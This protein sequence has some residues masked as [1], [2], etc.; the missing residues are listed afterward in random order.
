MT[1]LKRLPLPFVGESS[2]SKIHSLLRFSTT[3]VVL[4][5]YPDRR[6]YSVPFPSN[7]A[8]ELRIILRNLKGGSSAKVIF[9]VS[10]R[11]AWRWTLA[12]ASFGGL[13][14]DRAEHRLC[15]DAESQSGGVGLGGTNVRR[16]RLFT[17]WPDDSFYGRVSGGGRCRRR[18]FVDT[19]T[20]RRSIL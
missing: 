11:L 4:E 18:A 10:Q 8:T 6:I 20:G 3:K 5:S 13:F 15:P 17:D 16:R 2:N 14:T 1:A 7:L 9:H 19:S 12:P